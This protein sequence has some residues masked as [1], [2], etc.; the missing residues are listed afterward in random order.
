MAITAP[1]VEKGS[2]NN[3]S[4]HGSFASVQ[5]RRCDHAATQVARNCRTQPLTRLEQVL[6]PTNSAA[7]LPS[8]KMAPHALS[9]NDRFGSSSLAPKTAFASAVGSAEY[10]TSTC[11]VVHDFTTYLAPF[12]QS[13]E[14]SPSPQRYA[15]RRDIL[16]THR[17]F[18]PGLE[19]N[20]ETKELTW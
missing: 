20:P 18:A 1:R 19:V 5:A 17:T 7:S 11:L 16:V 2:G 9:A 13:G 3:A 15:A 6:P 8:L 10:L 14:L 4:F 12:C